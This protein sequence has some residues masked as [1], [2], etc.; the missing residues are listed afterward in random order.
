MKD[1]L[2]L[3]TG[4]VAFI[5][6]LLSG[7]AL[8][9]AVHV[10]RKGLNDIIS[11]IVFVL[12]VMTTLLFLVALYTDV[13][14]TIELAGVSQLNNEAGDILQRVRDIGTSF[15]TAGFVF[16]IFSIGLLGWIATPLIGVLT[17]MAAAATVAL[18]AYLWVAIGHLQS[19]I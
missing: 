13:R 18:L 19:A 11:Q 12:F 6:G 5:S 9:I 8:T 14:L 2:E 16:F 10:L 7:F 17:S 4:Q 3:G 1:L 15:A